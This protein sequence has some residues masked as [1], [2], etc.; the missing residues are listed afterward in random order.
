MLIKLNILLLASNA[1]FL[2][3]KQSTR[4][5]KSINHHYLN[6]L[7][8]APFSNKYDRHNIGAYHVGFC[9]AFNT[10]NPVSVVDASIEEIVAVLRCSQSKITF[11]SRMIYNNP[12]TMK[13][14]ILKDNKGKAGIYRWI[15][16]D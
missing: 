6:K 13:L 7:Q 1:V 11:V 15:H 16:V 5:Y 4:R 3:A 9:G 8:F 2:L 12:D 14:Y 10:D